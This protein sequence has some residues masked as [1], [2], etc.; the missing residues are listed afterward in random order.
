MPTYQWAEANGTILE[1]DYNEQND[2][3]SHDAVRDE[4]TLA[5]QQ[6]GHAVTVNPVSENPN[7]EV[8]EITVQDAPYSPFYVSIKEMTPG[9]RAALMD[10][11]RIQQYSR[12]INY[13]HARSVAGSKAVLMGVYKRGGETIFCA[14]KL[15]ESTAE[16]GTPISKQI[17]VGSIAA[18][19]REGFV[20]QDK[21]HGE[22]A[23]AFR[24]EFIF[25][26]I[27]NSDWLHDGQITELNENDNALPENTPQEALA[28][29]YD[30]VSRVRGGYNHLLYGVPGSGKSF[31]VKTQYCN[32]RERME[33][34]VFHPDYT[35]SDFVG[36]ILPRTDGENISYVF[37]PGPFTKLLRKAYRDPDH[38]YFL[39]IEEINRGNAPAIFGEVFQLLDR[40]VDGASEYG[41]T[42]SD[43]AKE[44]YDNAD[45]MVELPSNFSIVATMN[46]SDQ[47]VFTLDTAFQRRWR[48]R[49]IENDLDSLEPEFANHPILDTSVTW[50][51][52]N[53]TINELILEANARLSSS[54]DKRLGTHFVNIQDLEFDPREDDAAVTV[55][56]KNEASM[57]NSKF[58]E[59]ILKYLW[60]DAF[61]FARDEIFEIGDFPS[62]EALVKKFRDSRGNERL[63]VFTDSIK[64]N[65]MGAQ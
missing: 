33:R 5:L 59:K 61:K 11:Q 32:T 28:I 49:M 51:Q 54:E 15:K 35:Y 30:A 34:V 58:P 38:K 18:A 17:K 37:V 43:I 24:K 47:N 4:L 63:R 22:Y 41:I 60:D 21:G 53:K 3:L 9:G 45:R 27:R 56:V 16:P 40:T 65:L 8:Y 57:Q 6:F 10:E 23:C 36:Q 2:R 42:N 29:N 55:E 7:E 31:T 62:L 48:M 20:Q 64:G 46:T 44:V 1:A 39:I 13:A 25:F 26:Y 14:W 50:R 19:M 12:Y 52:F